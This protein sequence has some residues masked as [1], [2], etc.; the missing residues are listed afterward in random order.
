MEMKSTGVTLIYLCKPKE[1]LKQH[2]SER[3][4]CDQE[5]TIETYECLDAIFI[6]VAEYRIDCANK[7]STAVPAEVNDVMNN[8]GGWK[9]SI[10]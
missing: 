1:Q 4:E 5:Y 3:P 7:D 8:A 9:Q 6:E 2:L 10:C